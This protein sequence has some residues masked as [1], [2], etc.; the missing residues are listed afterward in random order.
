[1]YVKEVEAALIH[2]FL[3]GMLQELQAIIGNIALLLYRCHNASCGAVNQL[4]DNVLF[5]DRDTLSPREYY[6]VLAVQWREQG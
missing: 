4:A 6:Y 2:Q 3:Y 5:S 1:M